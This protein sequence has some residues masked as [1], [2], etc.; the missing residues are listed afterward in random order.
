MDEEE[1]LRHLDKYLEAPADPNLEMAEVR[2]VW[3][4]DNPSF[5]ARHIWEQHG[6]TEEDVEQVLFE[7]PPYVE[8]RRHPD[9]PN[10]TIFWGAT[11][12]D[13]WIFVVCEDWI[14]GETRYLRPITS[15]EPEEGREYWEKYR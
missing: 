3:E 15:F 5:G 12:N 4:R 11:R 1:F 14:E 13:R 7:V 6:I 10:R 9:H 2:I 8:A